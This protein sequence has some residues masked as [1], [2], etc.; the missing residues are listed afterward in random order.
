VDRRQQ[1]HL[2]TVVRGTHNGKLAG[3]EQPPVASPVK[4]GWNGCSQPVERKVKHGHHTTDQSERLRLGQYQHTG[5]RWP[6][7]QTPT[8]CP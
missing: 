5:S 1:L 3:R 7:A 8:S 2:G 6:K 4:L